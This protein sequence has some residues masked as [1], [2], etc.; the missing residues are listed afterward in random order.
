MAL[1]RSASRPRNPT[2]FEVYI[3]PTY[4]VND[5]LTVGAN[6]FYTPSYL[7]TG[8][9]GEYLSG[10]AKVGLP[11]PF[12]AVALS[13]EFGHQWLG[14]VDAVYTNNNFNPFYTYIGYSN[15]QLPSYNYWNVG[16]SYVWKFITFDVRYYG[17]DLSRAQAYI[18]TGIPNSGNV[19][20]GFSTNSSYAD[21]RFVGTI[22]FDLTSKDLKW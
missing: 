1:T 19:Q 3:K 17:T 6:F 21:D 2:F 15:G 10:T 5:W 8:A 4:T 12:S 20:T 13:G 7:N 14:K 18:L 22:S 16:L 9:N 11:G